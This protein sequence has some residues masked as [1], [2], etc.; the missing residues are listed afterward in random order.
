ML[1]LLIV[2]CRV[3]L[4]GVK[5]CFLCCCCCLLVGV[6]YA[7]FRRTIDVYC[8][9]FAFVVHVVLCVVCLILL[10]CDWFVVSCLLRVGC[11]VLFVECC[12]MR[13]S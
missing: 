1:C 11:C 10:C 2:V 5:R 13:G 3:S 6:M 9:L 7:S 4:F 8:L 12:L